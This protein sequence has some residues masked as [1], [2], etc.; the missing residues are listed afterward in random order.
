M[1]HACIH[2]EV[3]GLIY[4]QTALE[5]IL[6]KNSLSLMPALTFEPYLSNQHTSKKERKGIPKE[7]TE[8]QN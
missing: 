2:A 7:R 3:M 4:T 8:R 6:F 5:T 1:N